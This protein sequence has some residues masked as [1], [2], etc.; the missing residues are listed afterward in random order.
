MNFGNNV[1]SRTKP[2]AGLKKIYDFRGWRSDWGWVFLLILLSVLPYANTLMNGFV[3]DDTSQILEN[4]YI[5]SFRYLRQIFGTAVWSFTGSP[6]RYYRPMMTLGYLLCYKIFGL[7]P[8][9]FHLVS[10]GLH[11]AVVCLLFFLTRRV[12]GERMLA[13]GTAAL[14]ALHPIHSESVTWIAAV[15]DLELMA[16]YVLTFWLFLDLGRFEGVRLRLLQ[17]AMVASFALAL[18]SKEQ[19]VTLPFLATVYEHFYRG[20]RAETTGLRKFSRYFPLWVLALAYIP[21][22]LSAL[23]GFVVTSNHWGMTRVETILSALALTG[24]YLWKLIW[25][26]NLNAF[27]VFHKSTSM[28]DGYVIAG[29][30]CGILLCTGFWWLWRYARPFSFALIWL[31]VT[32]AP[33]MNPRWLGDN[34]FAE[35]YLYLPSVGFCWIGAWGLRNLWRA[36]SDRKIVWRGVFVGGLALLLVLWSLRIVIR[37]RDWQDDFVLFSRTLETS[38]DASMIRANLANLYQNQGLMSQAEME[39]REALARDPACAD[40]L[41]Q[42]GRL[43]IGQGRNPEAA[44]VLTR[45]IQLAP[46]SLHAHLNLGIAYERIGQ[47]DLAE[48]QL[49]AA[50]AISPLNIRVHIALGAFYAN[51]GDYGRAEAA[52]KRALSANPYNSQARIGLGKIYEADHRRAEAIQ[53]FEVALQNE[54]GAFEAIEGLRRLKVAN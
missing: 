24:Q 10:V 46:R 20:D 42:F 36:V 35:R 33:V 34:V 27:Y 1:N 21:L 6:S 17:M 52:L 31:V 13:V 50:A 45:A 2:R 41:N 48:Q 19:A 5:R 39:Y 44:K 7:S 8:A 12:F 37:N 22:R 43:L 28:L 25:P 26:V 53:E 51:R 4:P 30:L 3:Y 54:P 11:A 23:G 18:L 15:T 38:P 29:A 16:F 14:F 47:L 9:G 40:C 49:R 32:L